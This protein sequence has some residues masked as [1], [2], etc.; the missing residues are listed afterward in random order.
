[1]DS[2]PIELC[3]R[4]LVPD[5]V[6][7]AG[8]RRLINTRLTSPEARDGERRTEAFR[9]LL[10]RASSGPIAEH[11]DDA[12]AQHYEVPAPFFQHALGPRLKYSGCLFESC[13]ADL[14]A[15]EEAM[16]QRTAERAGIRDGHT[17]LDLGCGWGSFSLWAA[18]KFPDCRI[19]AVSN[20]GGQKTHIDGVASERGLNNLTVHTCDI[21]EFDPGA[22]FDRIVSVEMFEHMRNLGELMRRIRGWLTDD[23]RLFVHIFCHKL[24]AYPFLDEGR[25]DWMARHFFTG[26][27]MPSENLLLNLADDLVIRDHWWVSG[28]HYEATSNAWLANMDAQRQAVRDIFVPTYGE[29]GADRWI[30]RWRMF[31][32]AVAELFGTNRGNEWGVG[33]YLFSPR[34]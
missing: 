13:D 31:F 16:L 8:M 6:A 17:I 21:N 15:A 3:E 2:L 33:H 5:A 12:N 18:E 14:P 10:E 29:A 19:T 1:M 20:S 32:M 28:R 23:G 7:R 24:L 11:T 27:I 34:S 9:A 25:T 4:G 26:G 22:R 30:Q